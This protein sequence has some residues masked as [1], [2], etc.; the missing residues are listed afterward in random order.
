MIQQDYFLRLVEEF[1]TALAVMMKKKE[2]ERDDILKDMYRQYIGD[3]TLLRNMSVEELICYANN[4]WDDKER[5]D[6][7]EMLAELLYAEGSYKTNPLR[8]MLL[9]KAYLLFAYVDEKQSVY[10]VERKKKIA[11]LHGILNQQA[12]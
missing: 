2:D 3:Y 4:E 8:S 11:N 5:I 10:S 9:N 6:R 12:N 7:L 1:A